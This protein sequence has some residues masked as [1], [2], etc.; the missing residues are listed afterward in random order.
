MPLSGLESSMLIG[1]LW[2]PEADWI[3]FGAGGRGTRFLMFCEDIH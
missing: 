3:D 2:K 1:F